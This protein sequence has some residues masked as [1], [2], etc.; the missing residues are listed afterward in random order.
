[1]KTPIVRL[2]AIAALFVAAVSCGGGGGDV[3]EGPSA[4]PNIF[5]LDARGRVV[6]SFR[7]GGRRA[8][9]FGVGNGAV[10]AIVVG[11]GGEIY[12]SGQTRSAGGECPE[13]VVAKLDAN[14]APGE[15]MPRVR[16]SRIARPSWEPR[17]P[18]S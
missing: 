2:A 5:K 9:L 1:M 7:D 4:G 15:S 8:G 17:L 13:F 10:R 6:D 18:P 11:P 14:G 12:A 3:A 16:P